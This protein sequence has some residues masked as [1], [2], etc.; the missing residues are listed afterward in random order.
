MNSISISDVKIF[1]HKL[2]A[3]KEGIFKIF[4]RWLPSWLSPNLLSALR[5][6]LIIPIFFLY[7]HAQLTWVIIIFLLAMLTDILDGV[8][9]R[10][11]N[12]ITATGKLL[13]P[14]A[15][16]VIFVGLFLLAAPVKINHGLIIA[17]IT[18]EAVLV[19]LA[20]VIGPLA[21]K[22]FHLELKLG[23]NWAGKTKMT[24]EASA[25]T[26]LLVGWH[27]Q[28]ITNICQIIFYLATATAL[29]SI[30][31]HLTSLR[32]KTI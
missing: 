3:A 23:A 21:A 32:R 16:K 7:R 30:I 4:T 17:L 10:A 2:Y 22:I 6:F 9:A 20:T 26:L 12:K 18:M 29:L 25:L 8:V 24:L 28:I 19:L 5:A 14:A 15:D 27:N 11:Q 13:D 31:L 1:G